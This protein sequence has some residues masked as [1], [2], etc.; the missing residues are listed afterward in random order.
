MYTYFFRNDEEIDVVSE[1]LTPVP[2]YDIT[3][4]RQL[5]QECETHVNFVRREEVMDADE[6]EDRVSRYE[7]NINISHHHH[8]SPEWTLLHSLAFH[9]VRSL[10]TVFLNNI[11]INLR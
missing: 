6:W 9:S 8:D 7:H 4:V 3:K 1:P 10:A 11:N 5:M 2:P